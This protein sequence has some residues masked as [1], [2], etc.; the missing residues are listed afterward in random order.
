MMSYSLEE[1]V[2]DCREALEREGQGERA[3]E[4]VRVHLERLLRDP[5]FITAHC[6]PEAAPGISALYRDPD[7]GFVVL[8]HVYDSGKTSAPH[9]HGDSWAVYGQAGEHTE[10]TLWR[11][12]DDGRREGHAEVEPERTFRL[13]PGMAA[14]FGPGAIHSIHFPGP[15]RFMRVT[16]ADLTTIATR[17]FDPEART[18]KTSQRTSAASDARR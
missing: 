12:T 1:F 17:S 11:R 15:S 14:A 16:G 13:D 2:S 8:C 18:V 5:A 4:T 7:H 6:G 9:D 3:R 10:M